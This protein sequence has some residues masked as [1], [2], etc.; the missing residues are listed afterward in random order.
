MYASLDMG[1]RYPG[2]NGQALKLRLKYY[3]NRERGGEMQAFK[4][5]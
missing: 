3:F 5:E 4:G 2:E 1:D